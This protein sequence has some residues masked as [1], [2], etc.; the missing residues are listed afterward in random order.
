[1]DDLLLECKRCH[2]FKPLD[3]FA[4]DKRHSRR[5]GKQ[6]YCR[7]CMASYA[8]E[9][10]SRPE[11]RVEANRRRRESGSNAEYQRRHRTL[12]P[13]RSRANTLKYK[14]GVTPEWF[15]QKLAEQGGRCACCGTDT[16]GGPTGVFHIDH[17][18]GCCPGKRSCG[19]CLRGLLCNR[20]NWMLGHAKDDID[21]L[22]R[23]IDYLKGSMING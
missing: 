17:D 6:S 11:V 8:S 23:A 22:A 9:Y 10:H 14:Y 16:P 18:H 21:V 7:A 1:M 15:D 4:N 20:C 19:K 3:D 13:E 2:E 12:T 5:H